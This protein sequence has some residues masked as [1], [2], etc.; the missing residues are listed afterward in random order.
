[1]GELSK[2]TARAYKSGDNSEYKAQFN[3]DDDEITHPE[4][5]RQQTQVAV[6]PQQTQ[7]V[8]Q[9]TQLAIPISDISG[10]TQSLR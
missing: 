6:A 9:Q 2:A 1:M 10:L 4:Q 5:T 3:F 7:L 8:P